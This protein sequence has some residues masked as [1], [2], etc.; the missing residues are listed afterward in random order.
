[1]NARAY[2]AAVVRVGHYTILLYY[3]MVAAVREGGIVLVVL[4]REAGNVLVACCTCSRA[5]IVLEHCTCARGRQTVTPTA[6]LTP[7]S[8]SHCRHARLT[9]CHQTC[10]KLFFFYFELIGPPEPSLNVGALLST[11]P[12]QTIGP[13]CSWEFGVFCAQLLDPKYL[14]SNQSL[15]RSLF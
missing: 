4:V 5:G 10:S 12:G 7:T 11:F 13:K 8:G 15:A 9:I 6:P 1:M 2:Q 3:T 14:G